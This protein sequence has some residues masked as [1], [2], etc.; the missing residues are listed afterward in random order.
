MEKEKQQIAEFAATLESK[1]Q[2]IQVQ[3]NELLKKARSQGQQKVHELNIAFEKEQKEW[4]AAS[5]QALIEYEEVVKK[6]VEQ[7]LSVLQKRY[8]ERKDTALKLFVEEVFD[9]GHR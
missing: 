3:E 6:Q 2:G 7:E 5:Q 4:E 8:E 1:L 9:Y